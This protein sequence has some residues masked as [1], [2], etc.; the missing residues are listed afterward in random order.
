MA[1]AHRWSE[2]AGNGPCVV[3]LHAGIADA[4]MWDPQ[5]HAL[6]RDHRV[7]RMDLAGYGRSPL[8]PGALCHADDVTLAMDR[9]DMPSATLVGASLGGAVAL[10][11]AL[12]RPERVD[13]LVL[14]AAP[15][16][17]TDWSPELRAAWDH[18]EQALEAGDLDA[19]VEGIVRF[20][21]DGPG[22]PAGSAPADV[23]ALVAQM[24]RRAFEL[25]L[26]LDGQT[27]ETELVEDPAARL[28]E[29]DRP[30]LVI[31]GEHDVADFRAIARRLVAELSRAE[32]VTIA[33]AAHLPSLE[34]PEAF[35]DALGAFL[36]QRA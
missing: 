17:G 12:G 8:E 9:W 31:D 28:G 1:G 36:A 23:R 26:P 35:E 13:A 20:W 25:Q 3:L 21:V 16:A 14:A 4:R 29:L 22:R 7:L 32:A 18:E 34:Q 6:A 24:Q 2:V 33:G 11:L 27:D 15:L 5:F 19:A 30:V 10:D